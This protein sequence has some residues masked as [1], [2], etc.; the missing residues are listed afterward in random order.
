VRLRKLV[1]D[2]CFKYMFVGLKVG[3]LKVE[4]F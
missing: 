2:K 1:S 4:G 3:R